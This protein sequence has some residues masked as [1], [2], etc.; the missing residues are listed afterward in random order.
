VAVE[1]AIAQAALTPAPNLTYFER[2]GA[3]FIWDAF[4]DTD[5]PSSATV[6]SPSLRNVGA[7]W[8]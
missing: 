6:H 1:V 8:E 7:E 4:P 2:E 5:Q 3:H